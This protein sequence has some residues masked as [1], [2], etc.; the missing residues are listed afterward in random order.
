MK[1]LILQSSL[2]DLIDNEHLKEEVEG[3][4]RITKKG[5]KSVLEK[6]SEVYKY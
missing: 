4:L 2:K 1:L 6:N 5:I 3:K